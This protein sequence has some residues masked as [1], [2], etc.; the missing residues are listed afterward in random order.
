ME[1]FVHEEN[2]ASEEAK[3]DTNKKRHLNVV[4][5]GHVGELIYLYYSL[6]CMRLF[7]MIL[8][9]HWKFSEV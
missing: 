8:C 6:A 1:A 9:L 7:F 4:F 2:E 3:E 5:I